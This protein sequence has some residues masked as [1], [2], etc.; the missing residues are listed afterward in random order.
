M[1]VIEAPQHM[2]VSGGWRSGGLKVW[3][4]VRAYL[5]VCAENTSQMSTAGPAECKY[6][7]YK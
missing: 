4:P 5:S 3:G 1:K 6:N 2:Y 7:S